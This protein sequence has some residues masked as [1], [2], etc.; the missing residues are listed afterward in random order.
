MKILLLIIL[1]S[2]S[3]Y[4]QWQL[5][6]PKYSLFT[7]TDIFV[8][9]NKIIMGNEAGEIFLSY[10]TGKTIIKTSQIEFPVKKIFFSDT[11]NGWI[12]PFNQKSYYFTNDGGYNWNRFELNNVPTAVYFFDSLY[13]AIST[14]FYRNSILLTTNGGYTWEEI[15]DTLFNSTIKDIFLKDSNTI[16]VLSVTLNVSKDKGKTWALADTLSPNSEGWYKNLF[17]LDS[18]TGFITSTSFQ[19][20]KTIDGGINWSH[21]KDEEFTDNLFED[22]A[23]TS[24]TIFLTEH[25]RLDEYPWYSKNY[26]N[27]DYYITSKN[28]VEVNALGNKT[29]S[30]WFDYLR[31]TNAGLSWEHFN[32]YSGKYTRPAYQVAS[33]NDST[34]I[35]SGLRSIINITYDKGE[36]FQDLNHIEYFDGVKGISFFNDNFGIFVA[37]KIY[38][39]YDGGKSFES[40]SYP[41]KQNFYIESAMSDSNTIFLSNDSSTIIKSTDQGYTWKSINLNIPLGFN[42]T[43]IKFVNENIGFLAAGDYGIFKTEDKGENWHKVFDGA[44]QIE[45][46]DEFNIWL[47]YYGNIYYSNNGGLTWTDQGYQDINYISFADKNYGISAANGFKYTIDG[48]VSWLPGVI[49]GLNGYEDVVALKFIKVK[50]KLFGFAAVQPI[51][52]YDPSKNYFTLDSGKT[53]IREMDTPNSINDYSFTGSTLWASDYTRGF[54]IKRNDFE[55]ITNI[56]PEI[57]PQPQSFTLSQ[58]YPNPFNPSTKI[59]YTLPKQVLVTIKVYNVLGKE[60]IQLVNEEKPSGEYEVEFDGSSLSSGIYFYQIQSGEFLDTKKMVLMK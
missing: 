6:N 27:Q 56:Q 24:N 50:D 34:F 15:F 17:F 23:Y 40:I 28:Y 16:F 14:N 55:T 59:K 48:G 35:F 18:L 41:S 32:S 33:F 30:E 20:M 43:C 57:E 22:A 36:T 1:L 60:I 58:N 38:K 31:S 42:V 46:I 37:N 54:L 39:T 7:I 9:E 47:S 49:Q 3:I 44:Y 26:E 52:G 21:F 10:D 53:W 51:D 29:R 25:L 12:L 13:G 2:S 5:V 4:P 45:A 11:T 19:I 8:K